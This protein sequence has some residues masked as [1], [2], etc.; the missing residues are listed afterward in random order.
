MSFIATFVL[1]DQ[2]YNLAFV[3]TPT[4]L[5]GEHFP[6]SLR[7]F[8][9]ILI[10]IFINIFNGCI[11]AMNVPLFNFLIFKLFYFEITILPKVAKIARRFFNIPFN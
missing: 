8:I 2:I 1:Y 4:I 9:N 11:I 3:F 6:M 5:D 7:L 10:L